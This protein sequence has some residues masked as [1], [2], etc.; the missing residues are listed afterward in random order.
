MSSMVFTEDLMEGLYSTHRKLLKNLQVP[1]IKKPGGARP[2]FSAPVTPPRCFWLLYVSGPVTLSL[3][4]SNRLHLE[5][6]V[7]HI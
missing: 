5:G 4:L 7:L 1:S 2:A 6:G 3:H